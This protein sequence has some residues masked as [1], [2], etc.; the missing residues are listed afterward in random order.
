M[1][2]LQGKCSSAKI[3]TDNADETTVSQV[4][5]FCNS[6]VTSGCK[7][8]IMPDCHAGAGCVIGTTATVKDKIIP[9]VVGVDIGCGVDV[10]AIEEKEIDFDRLDKII[11][12]NIPFGQNAHG[13]AVKQAD[14]IDLSL[15]KCVKAINTDRAYKSIMSLGGGEMIATRVG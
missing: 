5:S 2:E 9:G 14:Q 1:F 15:L 7:V 8:R 13:K 4:M 12:K 10:V 11:R 6:E 3:F